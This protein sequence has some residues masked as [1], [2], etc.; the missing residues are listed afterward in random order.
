MPSLPGA[1]EPVRSQSEEPSAPC[2]GRGQ[3]LPQG[4]AEPPSK[5]RLIFIKSFVFQPDLPIRIDYEAKGFKTEIVSVLAL[6]WLPCGSVCWCV[7]GTVAGILFGLSHL[8]NSEVSLKA[9]HYKK[10]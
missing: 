5:S 7:Q 1:V 3:P 2:S 8:N 9:L 10:G 4:K 6:S